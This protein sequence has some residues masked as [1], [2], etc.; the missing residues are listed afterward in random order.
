MASSQRDMFAS[1][2]DKSPQVPSSLPSNPSYVYL[3]CILFDWDENVEQPFGIY[4]LALFSPSEMKPRWISGDLDGMSRRKKLKF[5]AIPGK[6]FSLFG[7]VE[8]CK[9]II[10]MAIYSPRGHNFIIQQ[11]T[12]RR[13]E[14]QFLKPWMISSPNLFRTSTYRSRTERLCWPSRTKYYLVLYTTGPMLLWNEE[15]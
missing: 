7:K 13:G 11:T 15:S 4:Q 3:W 1:S 5:S 10:T 9:F 2:P 6:T 8:K 12:T 14:I